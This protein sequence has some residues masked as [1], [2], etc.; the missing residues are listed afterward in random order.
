M[1]RAEVAEPREAGGEAGEREKENGAAVEDA[2]LR[3]GADAP[4]SQREYDGPGK[5]DNYAGAGAGWVG[6]R[7]GLG[8]ASPRGLISKKLV[9][10][11]MCGLKLVP[12]GGSRKATAGPSTPLRFAQGP[13]RMTSY[14]G[15]SG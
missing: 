2:N 5:D 11:F 9:D 6:N 3:K 1:Q 14:V 15:C 7:A 8:A 10:E 12:I 4:L 13:L